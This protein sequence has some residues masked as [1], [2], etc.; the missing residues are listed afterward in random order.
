[1]SEWVG[2]STCVW[3]KSPSDVVEKVHTGHLLKCRCLVPVWWFHL[4][5][6]PGPRVYRVTA[7]TLVQVV[8]HAHLEDS[9]W[10][11]G[12][13]SGHEILQKLED[14]H[15]ILCGLFQENGD[16]PQFSSQF[17]QSSPTLCDP[18]NFSTPGFPVHHHL[19]E[20]GQTHVPWISNA[21]QPSCPLLSPPP[22]ALNFSQ[23]QG[24]L[25]W[26][27]SGQQMAKVYHI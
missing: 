23:H 2:V 8:W 27:S 10:E 5:Q 22:L 26:V 25:Q 24:L 14:T 3:R 17:S 1:M 16:S 12:G 4:G 21:I 11:P 6:S 13:S 19:P 20:L 18:M 7:L 9:L 15:T